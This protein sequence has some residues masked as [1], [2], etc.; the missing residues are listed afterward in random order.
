M[1]SVF[2]PTCHASTVGHRRVR[3]ATVVA[4]DADLH[5]LIR[6]RFTYGILLVLVLAAASG[7]IDVVAYLRYDVFVANQTGNL[8][9]ISLGITQ[10]AANDPLLPSLISLA[11]FIIAAVLTARTRQ[12]LVRNGMS[13]QVVRHGALMVEAVFLIIV[14]GVMVMDADRSPLTR[15]AVIGL[16]AASQGIQAVVLVRALGVAVQTVAINAPLISTVSLA[17]KGQRRRA[18]VA[19]SAPVGY[20]LGAVAGALLQI[21][22]SAVTLVV[23]AA[24][25]VSAVVIGQRYHRLD[26]Q[27]GGF[28]QSG[29]QD[30]PTSVTDQ[31]G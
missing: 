24:L 26:V 8:I 17:A 1:N 21:L 19:G 2:P 28:D 23:A 20:A 25:G 29:S 18:V 22:S 5:R 4:M 13:D 30:P 31:G 7:S 12:V 3:I 11:A 14:A 27:V 9:I 16:L 15:F 6:Q 10:S